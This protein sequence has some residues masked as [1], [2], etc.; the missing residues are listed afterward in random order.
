VRL[1]TVPELQRFWNRRPRL[2]KGTSLTLGT[3]ALAGF[4]FWTIHDNQTA[5]ERIQ[6]TWISPY[7]AR[8]DGPIQARK[9]FPIKVTYQNPGKEP[10]IDVSDNYDGGTASMIG[11]NQGWDSLVIPPNHSCDGVKSREG[12]WV[13]YPSA[14]NERHFA[15]AADMVD[16]SLVDGT[17]VLCIHGC[18]VY[19][20]FGKTHRSSYCFYLE[21]IP[22]QPSEKWPLKNC[23]GEGQANAD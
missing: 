18:F 12:Q 22:D 14:I 13:V 16:Q 20:T 11:R 4:A 5:L 9:D 3:W 23:P 10:A 15:A 7:A 1:P 19:T 17:R 21:P 6:R 8:H 2:P